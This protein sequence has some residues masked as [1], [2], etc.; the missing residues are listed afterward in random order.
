MQPGRFTPRLNAAIAK[1]M[2]PKGPHGCQHFPEAIAIGAATVAKSRRL[3]QPVQL[4][5]SRVEQIN[6]GRMA[7]FSMAVEP[8]CWCFLHARPWLGLLRNSLMTQARART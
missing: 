5:N 6:D 8:S 2:A 4:G 3:D 1:L 7:I